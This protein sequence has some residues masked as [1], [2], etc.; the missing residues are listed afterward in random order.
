MPP[1][2]SWFSSGFLVHN[3]YSEVQTQRSACHGLILPFLFHASVTLYHGL[4]WNV[5]SSHTV[6]SP[7]SWILFLFK[8]PSL[9]ICSR[10]AFTRHS[11]LL[12][13]TRCRGHLHRVLGCHCISAFL[14]A[15]LRLPLFPRCEHLKDLVNS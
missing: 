4:L 15:H 6:P 13:C 8:R 12:S 7:T 9:V 5:F 1:Q 10:K 11:S 3:M 2:L 14:L